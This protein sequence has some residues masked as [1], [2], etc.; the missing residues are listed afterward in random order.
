[1]TWNA[2]S[3]IS[4]MKRLNMIILVLKV[5]MFAN[6]DDGKYTTV[7]DNV[8]YEEILKN[9]R[10][11]RF[12]VNCLLDKGPCT[13]EGRALRSKLLGYHVMKRNFNLQFF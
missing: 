12:Y 5:V 6:S 3:K 11:L 8:R 4:E 7:Y 9:D 2:G 10:L 13:P 1:M